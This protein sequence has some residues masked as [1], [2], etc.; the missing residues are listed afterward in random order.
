M[1]D[2]DLFCPVLGA[3]MG[4]SPSSRGSQGRRPGVGREKFD[5]VASQGVEAFES[6]HICLSFERLCSPWL[7]GIPDQRQKETLR[8]K[9]ERQGGNKVKE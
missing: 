6:G 1:W 5:W 7:A 4:W 8:A 2:L 9:C 3:K